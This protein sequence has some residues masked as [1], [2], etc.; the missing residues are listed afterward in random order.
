MKDELEAVLRTRYPK[1]LMDGARPIHVGCNDGWYS[2][3]DTLC[4]QLQRETDRRGAPQVTACQI[5]QKL[6]GLR[7]YAGKA[8]EV[9][10]AQIR[11]AEAHSYRAC[12]TCGAMGQLYDRKGRISTCCPRHKPNG[13]I[14]ANPD[15]VSLRFVVWVP[16]DKSEI[17]E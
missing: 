4:E 5:K 7:F 3:I 17:S 15:D 12:E 6:G 10:H 16:A 8:S 1:I 11:F 13:A 2:L 9:Q 14:P